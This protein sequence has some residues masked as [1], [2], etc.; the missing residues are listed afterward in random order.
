MIDVHPAGKA[1]RPDE[2]GF[3]ARGLAHALGARHPQRFGHPGH[4]LRL[5]R[6]QLMIT[7]D[8]Q[9]DHLAVAAVDQQGLDAVRGSHAELRAEFGD[10]ARIRGGYFRER[11]PGCRTRRRGREGG[12]HL[13]IGGVIVSVREDD[14]VL[15]R[16]GQNVKFLRRTAADAAAVGLHRA[17]FQADARENARVRLVHEAV[18]LGK[19]RL[20]D[21]KGIGILHQE[22]ARAH[23]AEAR[24]NFIAELRLNL[25]EIHRQLLVAAQFA[26]RD[27]GDDLLVSRAVGELAVMPILE[28]QQFRTVLGPAA[29]FLPQ[30]RRLYGRHGQFQGACAIHL[31]AHDALHLAQRAQ[32]QRQP[33]IQPGR[34]AADHAGAQ[35]ELVADDL[36]VGGH[37]FER[38]NRVLG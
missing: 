8:H 4:F 12:G 32:A 13:E 30:F 1:D 31:L 2:A 11:F 33:N 21:M 37:F 15:A 29:G 36:R 25:I 28:T 6:V 16:V 38:R 19:A 17:K 24:A 18:A 22:F 35:H 23:D 3:A 26:P 9:R 27:V 14:R 5:H 20:V 7:A 10:G 34:E